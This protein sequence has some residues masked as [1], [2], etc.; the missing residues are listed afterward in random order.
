MSFYSQNTTYILYKLSS[1]D[2]KEFFFSEVIKWFNNE[3][4]TSFSFELLFGKLSN[5]FNPSLPP[6]ML[7]KLNY[8]FLFAK[9]YIYTYKLRSEDFEEFTKKLEIKYCKLSLKYAQISQ[10]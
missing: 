1:K 4:G 8:V 3:N 5:E 6:L 7:K 2:L 9:H 10:K